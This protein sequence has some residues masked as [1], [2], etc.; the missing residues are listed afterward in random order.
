MLYCQRDNKIQ[1]RKDHEENSDQLHHKIPK[2]SVRTILVLEK[3]DLFDVQRK[4][5][6]LVDKELLAY[7]RFIDSIRNSMGS[8]IL[9]IFSFRSFSL[10]LC[11]INQ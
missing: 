8:K 5:I 2:G 10:Q 3:K 11:P 9:F 4:K 1:G 6:L 7:N